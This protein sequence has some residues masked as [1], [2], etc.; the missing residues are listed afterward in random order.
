MPIIRN[1]VISYYQHLQFYA[2]KEYKSLNNMNPDFIIPV[3]GI[4]QILFSSHCGNIPSLPKN[5][6]I[7]FGVYWHQLKRLQLLNIDILK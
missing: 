1:E 2:I 4:E 6:T 5:K 7:P 3:L